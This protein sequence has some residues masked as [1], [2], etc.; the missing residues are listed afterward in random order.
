MLIWCYTP[1]YIKEVMK[2]ETCCGQAYGYYIVLLI[3][4]KRSFRKVIPHC[5][6]QHLFSL[7][8]VHQITILV[9]YY[10]LQGKGYQVVTWRNLNT[11]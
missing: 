8:Q 11:V 10:T 6:L 2:E 7:D 1:G 3:G 4:S 9:Y 5:L